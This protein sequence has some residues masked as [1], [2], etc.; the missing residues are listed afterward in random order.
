[1]YKISCAGRRASRTGIAGIFALL[2]LSWTFGLQ[3]AAAACIPNADPAIRALQI[4]VDQDANAALKKV[5]QLLKTEL[6]APMPNGQRLASLYSVQ[7]Q[8]Y[9]ILELESKARDAVFKGLKYATDNTDPV[10]I[11]LLSLY[12][13]N[14]YDQA[15]IAAAVKTTEEAQAVQKRG[16]LEDICL[17]I[18]R[19]L[20]QYREDRE[21]L[22]IGSPSR[23][24]WP[25]ECSPRSCAAWATTRRRWR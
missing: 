8:A 2:M 13:E 11:M 12:A 4:L 20:L 6:T 17:L 21:D 7:A 16:S 3:P 24:F 25:P 9:S 19:G 23:T 5:A 15:G 10:R 14:V 18:G 1:M 22:A